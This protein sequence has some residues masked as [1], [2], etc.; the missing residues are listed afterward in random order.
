MYGTHS[1]NYV[2]RARMRLDE[3]QP[4]AL[5]YA[6]LELRLG[7][8][9]RMKDYLDAQHHISKAK[10]EGWRVAHLGKSLESVFRTGD[11]VIQLRILDRQ[12][13]A[14]LWVLYYTPV[15][16]RLQKMAQRLGD[17]LHA[18]DVSRDQSDPWWSEFRQLLEAAWLELKR[19]TMGALMGAP[20]LHT[21]T[22]KL[23]MTVEFNST[24]ERQRYIERVGGVGARALL[25]VDYLN[26]L[27]RETTLH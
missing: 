7:V 20:L 13:K 8:E 25:E 27:P 16:K 6:A 21:A 14:L 24:E 1:Q 17:Y 5:F 26:D 3:Q 22:G 9:A 23:N 18:P 4:E 2:E 12:S 11:K 15:T 19:A 10:K